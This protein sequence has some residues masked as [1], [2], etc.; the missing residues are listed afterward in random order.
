M[1][2]PMCSVL[3]SVFVVCTWVEVQVIAFLLFL[4]L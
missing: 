2:F 3:L 1:F 4:S